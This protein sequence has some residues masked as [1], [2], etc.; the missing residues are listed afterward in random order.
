MDV[1][2]S[3]V[4]SALRDE[5]GGVTIL[6]LFSLLLTVLFLGFAID[7]ANLYRHQAKLRMAADAGAHAGASALARGATPEAAEQSA[8]EIVALNMAIDADSLLADPGRDLRAMVLNPADGSLSKPDQD[9]PANAMLVN[10]QQSETARNQIPTLVLRLF[11]F[12]AW[13]AGSASVAVVSTTRRCGNA[14]GLFARGPITVGSQGN[15]LRPG[16]GL[17]VHSQ[18]ALTLPRGAIGQDSDPRLSLPAR[19]ACQ[20]AGCETSAEVNLIMEDLDAHIRRL[21][22]GFIEPGFASREKRAF[23]AARPIARDLEPL[24]EV[25]TE[26]QGLTTGGVVTLSP[27]RFRLLREVPPGLVYLVL[28][29]QSGAE[30]EAD[31]REEIVLG[32][33]PESPALHDV[34]LI[35]SCPIRLADHARIEGAFIISTASD[36]GLAAAAAGARIGDPDGACDAARRSVL[37]TTR[38]LVL[39]SHLVTSNVAVV[40]AGSVQLGLSGDATPYRARGIAVHAGGE[41]TGTGSQSFMPCPDAS[42]PLLP[43]LRVIS[44]TMPQLEGWVT[45]LHPREEHDL[46][47][48]RPDRLAVQ[49]DGRS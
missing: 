46:P 19:V 17:C 34:A 13:S 16:G 28:C 49:D 32:E 25:G 35:T 23:F 10:L 24:L 22:E 8:L 7:A 3:A 33:W 43:E 44:H 47:G 42:D 4:R 21:A 30:T 5:A 15:G 39:P 36:S 20:G 12:D 45:P 40:A 27:F 18:A 1:R 48:T 14:S 2:P 11:G 29:G 31:G 41:I 38:D 6:A 37:M 9:T 26:V